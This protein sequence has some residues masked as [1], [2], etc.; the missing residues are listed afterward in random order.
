MKER[1]L[2]V[3]DESQIVRALDR[4]LT[5]KGYEVIPVTS[6]EGAIPWIEKEMFDGVIAD[7]NLGEQSGIDLVR[8]IK[9]A[10][11][12]AACLV[13]TGYGTIDSAIE[14]VKAGAYHYLTKPFRL[15]D[16]EN[17]LKQALEVH[18]YRRE[19]RIL[20]QQVESRFGIKNLIGL[21]NPMKEIYSLIQK[22]A[23]TDSNVLILGESGTGKELVAKAIHYQSRR[24]QHPLITVNCGAIPEDLLESELFGHMKGS[25]TGAV[26]TRVGRFEMADRGS[27]FLDEIGDMSLK[28]QVK[29]LRVLQER[30]FEPVGSNKTL[31][32]DVRIIAA[33]N[34]NLETA[35][36]E[37][38]FREDLYYRLNVIPIVIPPLRNRPEDVPLLLDH[39]LTRFSEENRLK[40]PKVTAEALEILTHYPWPGNVR[41]LENT[42]ERLVVLKHEDEITPK[43]LPS[44]LTRSASQG[45]QGIS[46]P[47]SGINFKKLVNDFENDLILRALEKTSGNKNQAANLLRLNRTTLVEKIKKRQLGSPLP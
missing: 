45:S 24:T 17:L 35:V 23:D 37:G 22:V 25:F 9:Q 42:I 32:V 14:A 2:V 39:F 3:D 8:K 31:E 1:I 6:F 12:E 36:Q 30:R 27:I 40:K 11:P 28:L 18:R 26:S 4:F 16:V 21:S 44:H 19:N 46:I 20:R 29:L 47:E 43:G 34:K 15:E 7:L 5:E 41:E 13:I 38:R 33:T 10:Q